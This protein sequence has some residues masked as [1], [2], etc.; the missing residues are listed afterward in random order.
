[1]GTFVG[2]MSVVLLLVCLLFSGSRCFAQTPPGAAP[3]GSG[4][5]PPAVSTEA[6]KSLDRGEI[7]GMLKKL[8]DTPPPKKM[9]QGAMCYSS[10][11]PP[12]TATYVCP[13]CG[14]RTLYDESS[15]TPPLDRAEHGVAKF[16]EWSV[17]A[18]RRKL[19]EI[20][21]LAGNTIT[22]DESQF[23]R[24]CSPKASSPK[25]VLHV[26]YKGEKNTFDV[27]GIKY[28]DLLILK[29]LLAGKLLTEGD[30]GREYPLKDKLPRL[31]ELLGVK[32]E[33]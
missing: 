7:R 9:S 12:K 16:V 29:D 4:E 23:C 14:E 6:V 21:K 20:R 28:E 5:P 13:K 31:Q 33:K 15:K 19:D 3:A 10:A 32:L 26:S 30:Q 1:M 18:C 27:D 17:P 25:L 8:A 11:I 2:I 22:L 24:K